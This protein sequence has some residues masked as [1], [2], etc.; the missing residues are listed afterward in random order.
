MKSITPFVVIIAS[1]VLQSCITLRDSSE[2]DLSKTEKLSRLSTMLDDCL[3][4]QIPNPNNLTFIYFSHDPEYA[5]YYTSFL[6]L[7]L[8]QEHNEFIENYRLAKYK[9]RNC[10]RELESHP[11]GLN[12][13]WS[14]KAVIHGNFF[15]NYP[16]GG[17]PTKWQFVSAEETKESLKVKVRFNYIPPSKKSAEYYTFEEQYA[18]FI[19]T[20]DGQYL[21][22]IIFLKVLENTGKKTIHAFGED[23]EVHRGYIK[24]ETLKGLYK[25][26]NKRLNE[27]LSL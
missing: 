24:E 13:P 7:K 1:L 25:K 5:K 15:T 6:T 14:D 16:D 8:R 11:R 3:N 19:L 10:H 17:R 26:A 12:N 20:S 27:V 21:N 23:H 4:V 9:M 18:L 22:N 2:I